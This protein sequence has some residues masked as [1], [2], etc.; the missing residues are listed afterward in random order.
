MA[1]GPRLLK[2][3]RRQHL[4]GWTIDT[5]LAT[6]AGLDGLSDLGS[7][8]EIIEVS[9][10]AFASAITTEHTQ[11]VLSL[12]R[13]RTFEWTDLL[14][15]LPLVLVLNGIQ[16]P[17]NAGTLIRSAEAFG[18]T[19]V[20]LTAGSVRIS[21]AKLLRATAGSI[22]RLPY[23]EGLSTYDLIS[24]AR[25]GLQLYALDSKG[26]ETIHSIDLKRPCAFITGSEGHGISPELQA[27]A[28][29]VQIPVRHVESLNAAVAT[30]IALF[31]AAQRRGGVR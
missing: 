27:A 11:G 6:P 21:N 31:E 13:P 4:L 14:G 12:L 2:E 19:G 28:I 26:S 17:G 18:A 15:A 30:S 22:L 10:D 8:V 23:L 9:E 16:D 20:V 3:A 5:I 24:L 1:E 7:D 25:P 29:A